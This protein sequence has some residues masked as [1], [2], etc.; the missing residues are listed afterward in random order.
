MKNILM[1]DDDQE[2]CK[3]MSEILEDEGYCVRTVFDG[4]EGKRLFEKK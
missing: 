1:L 3:E 2:M 4:L